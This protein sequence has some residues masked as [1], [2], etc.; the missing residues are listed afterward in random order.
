[1]TGTPLNPEFVREHG[2]DY[3]HAH[4]SG[5]PSTD[6]LRNIMEFIQLQNSKTKSVLIHCGERMGRTGTVLAAYLVYNGSSADEA[7]R[8]IREKRPGSIQ[9]PEQE[10]AV[11]AFEVALRN[12]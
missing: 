3:L 12:R 5:A 8:L 9:T 11:R 2:F 4:I 10:T 6:Q 1:L 7:I